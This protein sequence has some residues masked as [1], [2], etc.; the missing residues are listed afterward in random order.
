VTYY[1]NL[2]DWEEYP[3]TTALTART[4]KMRLA[5]EDFFQPDIETKRVTLV[6]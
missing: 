1:R 4:R 2:L 5:M 3:D 6:L